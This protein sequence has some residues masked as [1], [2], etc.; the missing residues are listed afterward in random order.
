MAAERARQAV[1]PPEKVDGASLAVVLGEDAAG[2]I[3][4]VFSGKAVPGY[5]GFRDNFFPAELIGVPLR[6][7]GAGMV[8]LHH[9]QLEG[10]GF[11]I[12]KEMVRGKDRHGDWGEMGACRQ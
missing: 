2:F 12:G 5:C 9:G 8:V 11:G 1:A 3:L 10:K 4:P 6:E 7:R